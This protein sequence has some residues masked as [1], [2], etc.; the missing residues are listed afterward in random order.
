MT[1][2]REELDSTWENWQHQPVKPSTATS[3]W[4]LTREWCNYTHLAGEHKSKLSPKI[5]RILFEAAIKALRFFRGDRK[6][7]RRAMIWIFLGFTVRLVGVTPGF[8]V[9]IPDFLIL[10]FA[11]FKLF[12]QFKFF[13]VIFHWSRSFCSRTNSDRAGNAPTSS[14]RTWPTNST[15]LV[16]SCD[17]LVLW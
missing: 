4:L 9:F 1:I 5:G 8:R 2:S 10:L 7:P 13:T 15:V 14:K 16:I 6:N 3:A 11:V 12:K 17:W